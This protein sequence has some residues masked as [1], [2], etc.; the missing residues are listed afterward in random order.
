MQSSEALELE[1]QPLEPLKQ[2]KIKNQ[3]I[4]ATEI[5]AF[6]QPALVHGFSVINS[7]TD[8]DQAT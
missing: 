3:V 8:G 7:V 5:L 1:I 4:Y 6:A 2:V